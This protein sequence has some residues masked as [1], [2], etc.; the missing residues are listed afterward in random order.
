[1]PQPPAPLPPDPGTYLMVFF[2]LRPRLESGVPTVSREVLYRLPCAEERVGGQGTAGTPPLHLHQL[3]GSTWI[4]PF[5][6]TAS[7]SLG[8]IPPIQAA[9][10]P[11]LHLWA[12]KTSKGTGE[13]LAWPPWLPV[14]VPKGLEGQGGLAPCVTPRMEQKPL[15]VYPSTTSPGKGR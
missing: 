12:L 8:S 10:F 7:Q 1:M 3:E 6:L 5:S 14:T 4:L 2:S 15:P 11:M 13:T 9:K